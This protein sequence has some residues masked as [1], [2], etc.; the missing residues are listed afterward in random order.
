MDHTSA[1]PCNPSILTS[2]ASHPTVQILRRRSCD[3]VSEP[4]QAV[5]SIKKCEEVPLAV[6]HLTWSPPS[7][8]LPSVAR[9]LLPLGWSGLTGRD[10]WRDDDR[11]SASSSALRR[12]R[13]VSARVRVGDRLTSLWCRRAAC[14][15]PWTRRSRLAADETNGAT[16]SQTRGRGGSEWEEAPPADAPIHRRVRCLSSCAPVRPSACCWFVCFDFVRRWELFGGARRHRP[17]DRRRG[18]R[19]I[20]Q[21]RQ[22]MMDQR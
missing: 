11:L 3:V 21:T 8:S 22:D 15:A 16:D 12:A 6:A 13:R 2:L 18:P 9:G 14:G 4:L 19:A 1:Q 20:E 17:R 10:A 7:L 5:A